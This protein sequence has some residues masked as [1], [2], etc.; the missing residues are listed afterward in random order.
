MDKRGI[1]SYPD[2]TVEKVFFM[3]GMQDDQQSDSDSVFTTEGDIDL[4]ESQ[5][6]AVTID[7]LKEKVMTREGR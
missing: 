7:N 1:L 2:P 4:E 5:R 3:S 6:K